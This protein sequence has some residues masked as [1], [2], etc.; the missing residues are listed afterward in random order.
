[1]IPWNKMVH[2]REIK[3]RFQHLE[4][5]SA[6][7][8]VDL[9][10][11]RSVWGGL[12]IQESVFWGVKLVIGCFTINNPMITHKKGFLVGPNCFVLFLAS[13]IQMLWIGHVYF[14]IKK[15]KK[16]KIMGVMMDAKTQY[17]FR[18]IDQWT[19][20]CWYF[21]R[22]GGTLAPLSPSSIHSVAALP[23]ILIL[24]ISLLVYR[25]G[26]TQRS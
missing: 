1:M 26:F 7:L 3:T 11:R 9:G 20:G 21:F 6:P 16:V 10:I 25:I 13:R 12:H 19:L 18:M 8:I 2:M 24:D 23:L 15:K 14:F 22:G 4:N 5:C 17:L